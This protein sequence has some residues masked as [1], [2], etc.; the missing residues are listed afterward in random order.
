[1]RRLD[2]YLLGSPTLLLDGQ[3]I[4]VDRRKAVALLAYLVLE[5]R[6]HRRDALATLLWPEHSQA[7]ARSGLRRILNTLKHT[8]GLDWFQITRETIQVKQQG[9]LWVD[10]WRFREL[11]A[12]GLS[13]TC[14]CAHLQQAIALYRDDLLAGFTL[15]DA[16]AFEDWRYFNV[17]TLR[18]QLTD[19]FKMLLQLQVAAGATNDALNTGRRWLAVD[20][21]QEEAHQTLITLYL[22]TGNRAAALRQYE[23]CV[24]LLDRE[25]GL[26]PCA[27]TRALFNTIKTQSV[28][29][30]PL[31][32]TG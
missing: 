4:V 13:G 23:R 16:P 31:L 14:G 21:L 9:E 28:L 25:L 6:P 1:M 15:R 10:I 27:S 29:T 20:A 2:L 7:R 18:Q 22:A 5:P 12:L 24:Q 32:A 3:T 30:T 8:V 19:A 26:P 11:L 17:E